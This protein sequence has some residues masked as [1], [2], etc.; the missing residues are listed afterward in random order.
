MGWLDLD[1]TNFGPSVVGGAELALAGGLFI[2]CV[3]KNGMLWESGIEQFHYYYVTRRVKLH[4]MPIGGGMYGAKRLKPPQ[5]FSHL[6]NINN[7]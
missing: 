4:S 5:I 2:S 6:M 7:L 3:S 1:P